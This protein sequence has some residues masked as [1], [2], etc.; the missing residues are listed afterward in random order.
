MPRVVYIWFLFRLKCN[1]FTATTIYGFEKKIITIL[2]YY[3]RSCKNKGNAHKS[4]M[5]REREWKTDEIVNAL[6][7]DA[8]IY[9]SKTNHKQ[10]KILITRNL[11][12][13]VVVLIRL[14]NVDFHALN[15]NNKIIQAGNKYVQP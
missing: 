11:N 14:S 9:L 8:A 3:I 1:F 13:V 5:N 2:P 4:N 10:L 12:I 6:P 7:I 15:K